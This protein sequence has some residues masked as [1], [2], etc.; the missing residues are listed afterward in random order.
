M[1]K[2]KSDKAKLEGNIW[3][4]HLYLALYSLMFFTPIMV[5]FFQENGLSLTQIMVLQAISAL[6]FVLLEVPSGYFAD[7]FG[8]KKA[9]LV[10]AIFS[11]LTM[12]SFALSSNFYHFLFASI[13]WAIAGVFISGADSALLY[14]TLI[15]LKK[16]NLYK[17]IWGENCF[18]Y[19]MGISVAS[20]IGGIIG[21]I[22][23]RYTYYA[24]IPFMLL[25]I[26]LSLSFQEPKRHK[27]VFEK[28]HLYNLFRVMK[29][30]VQGNK[31]MKWLLIYAAV[32]AGF[33]QVA[34][35]L[36]QPYFELSGLKIVH[37]GLV[38][39]GFNVVIAISS[40]YSHR[41]EE[42]L[43]KK[44]SLISLFVLIGTSFLLMS[45]FIYFFSFTFALLIQFV[46]GFSQIVI[47]D[48]V[49]QLTASNIRATILS[50][51]SLIES[52][53]VAVISP[54]IGWVADIYSLQQALSLSGIIVLILGAI[55]I[56]GLWRSKALQNDFSSEQSRT[57]QKV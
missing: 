18:Y 17:K 54:L 56:L 6:L 53:F 38:F 3:K 25:L 49:H 27:P 14:D 33:V 8:R 36:S 12:V 45:N 28:E 15:D 1:K 4:L 5:L 31:Q 41:L 13:L 52:L 42:I 35:F 24:V 29:K 10:T 46:K 34:Y 48:Y 55:S 30:T 22:N 51:K 37:F 50:F 2:S 44:Y 21:S 57:C 32:I 23:Y 9:L 40:V 20:I 26:P 16:E 19:Y 39:A 7:M 11:V 43:G 47:S